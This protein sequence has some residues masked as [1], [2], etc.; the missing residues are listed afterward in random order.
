M[1]QPQIFFT[2]HWISIR[3]KSLLLLR[4]VRLE[5]L[6]NAVAFL[7]SRLFWKQA[8]SSCQDAVAQGNSKDMWVEKIRTMAWLHKQNMKWIKNKTTKTKNSSGTPHV[9]VATI[10]TIFEPPLWKFLHILVVVHCIGVLKSSICWHWQLV[11]LCVKFKSCKQ[12][13]KNGF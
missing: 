12:A 1:Y 8:V 4:I 2:D 7:P 6:K 5:H 3:I 11:Q 9:F 13:V 10:M